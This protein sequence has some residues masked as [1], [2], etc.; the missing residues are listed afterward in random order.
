M[1]FGTQPDPTDKRQ[2]QRRREEFPPPRQVRA[3]LMVWVATSAVRSGERREIN[4]RPSNLL[5]RASVLGW[6]DERHRAAEQLRITGNVRGAAQEFLACLAEA[7][8]LGEGKQRAILTSLGI[9]YDSLG[10][11]H[12]AI[13]HHDQALALSRE[14]DRRGE[15]RALGGL[16]NA[17]LSLGD[18]HKAIEHHDQALALLREIGDRR[19]R[20]MPS[21]TS[22]MRT[23]G[24]ATSTRRSSTMIRRWLCRVR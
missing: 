13:E 15:G 22:A 6:L 7:Q 16:G 14:V 18:F 19:V 3:R 2:V 10:D 11:F 8:Q 1:T 12:K 23:S 17:Y 4:V 24:W 21:A 20:A 5:D 9:A